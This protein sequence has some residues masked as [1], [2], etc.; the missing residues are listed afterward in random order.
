MYGIDWN[1]PV[2]LEEDLETVDVPVVESPLS[3]EDFAE[4]STMTSPYHDSD[5]FGADLYLNVIKFV[6]EKLSVRVIN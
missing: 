5:C 6:C 1:G 3:N 2:P 4:L